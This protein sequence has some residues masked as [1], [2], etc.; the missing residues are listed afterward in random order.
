M[1]HSDENAR[2]LH[3]LRAHQIELEMQNR[4]LRE[5]QGLLEESRA[6]Y[7]DL[8]DFAPVGYCR[9]DARGVIR[10]ANLEAAR[11]LGCHRA[12]LNDRPFTSVVSADLRRVQRHLELCFAKRQRTTTELTIKRRDGV[13]LFLQMSSILSGRPESCLTTLTDVSA[14]KAS[15]DRLRTLSAAGDHLVASLDYR[16]TLPAVLRLL[17][18]SLADVAFIDVSTLHGGIERFALDEVDRP[19]DFER[20][21]QAEVLRTGAQLLLNDANES[22]LTAALGR[23]LRSEAELQ[24]VKKGALLLVPLSAHGRCLGVATFIMGRSMRVY[25][26]AEERLAQEIAARATMAIES[27]RLYQLAQEAIGAREDVI[28]VVSHDLR[29]PLSGMRLSVSELLQSPR[30]EDQNKLESLARGIERMDRMIAD[31]LDLARIGA[32]R[33][34]LERTVHPLSA[35]IDEALELLRPLALQKRQ[36]LSEPT[37]TPHIELSC[38]RSRVLQVLA[39]IVGNAIQFT[40]EE[41]MVALEINVAEGSVRFVVRDSGPGISRE[42]R[43]HLFERYW[44]ADGHRQ[45]GAGL[46][47]FIAKSIVEAHGGKIGVEDDDAAVRGAIVWFTL[48]V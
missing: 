15:E 1:D 34:V 38:D 17:I 35:M 47:L 4:E 24:G 37:S 13:T 46:G 22:T 30:A 29:S 18:P 3:E 5:A 33:L 9:I 11:L 21:P 40:P 28:A 44:R 41:G 16:S 25:S 7:A 39:N 10:Q 12:E 48:P 45:S 27:S 2:L 42:Q 8:Y 23:P 31:L 32:G 20:S 43:S 14:L 19:L 6:L 26:P 36:T